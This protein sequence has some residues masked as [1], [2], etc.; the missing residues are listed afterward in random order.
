ML[1]ATSPPMRARSA[2]KEGPLPLR[3]SLSMSVVLVGRMPLVPLLAKELMEC[4]GGGKRKT[5]PEAHRGEAW[6]VLLPA[7]FRRKSG[8]IIS[9]HK[10]TLGGLI[11]KCERNA[12]ER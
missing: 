7:L 3:A 4:V 10:L 6:R 11:V 2:M 8:K 9:C 1:P 5:R 12:L